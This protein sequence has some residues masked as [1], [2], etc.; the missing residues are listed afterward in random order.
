MQ[1]VEDWSSRL[2]SQEVYAAMVA[3]AVPCGRYRDLSELKDDAQ[4]IH[5]GMMT[6]IEDAAG[7]YVVPNS[8][9]LFS[10]T[11]AAVER[12]V[13]SLGEHNVTLLRDELGLSSED[14]AKLMA[15]GAV[16]AVRTSQQS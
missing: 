4:L 13:A 7:A 6:E 9:F 2:S 10:E 12:H 5:R 8:P 3:A 15:N 16:G 1:L 14:I 11:H